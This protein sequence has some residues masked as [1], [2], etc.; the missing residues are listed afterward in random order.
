MLPGKIHQ[1]HH[2]NANQKNFKQVK[3]PE[4]WLRGEEKYHLLKREEACENRFIRELI[5]GV[6][7]KVI[8]EMAF[9]FMSVNKL[10]CSHL[11]LHMLKCM[12][13]EVIELEKFFSFE[14]NQFAVEICMELTMK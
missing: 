14:E 6:F 12:M 8:F 3:T 4:S 7:Q 1:S 13:D 2:E 9:S 11:F 10:L 5:Q